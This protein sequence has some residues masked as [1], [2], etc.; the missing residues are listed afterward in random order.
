MVSMVLMPKIIISIYNISK[1]SQALLCTNV[2]IYTCCTI[3]YI[4]AK[5]SIY[6]IVK[7]VTYISCKAIIFQKV[8]FYHVHIFIDIINT[9]VSFC[10]LKPWIKGPWFGMRVK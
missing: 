8:C 5:P 3:R 4:Q 6:S 10:Y 2:I 9:V 1:S 7:H